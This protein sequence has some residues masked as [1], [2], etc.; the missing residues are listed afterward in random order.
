[1]AEDLVANP[2]IAPPRSLP[3]LRREVPPL[4]LQVSRALAVCFAVVELWMY[5]RWLPRWLDLRL[6]QAARTAE[7]LQ[8]GRPYTAAVWAAAFIGM[9]ALTGWCGTALL[10]LW[11]RSS[12]LF[13]VLIFLCFVSAGVIGS[14]DVF[15]ILR[16]QRSDQWAPWP[17]YV[18]YTANALCILWVFVFPDG[19]FVPPW[20]FLFALAWIAWNI[21]RATLT[22]ADLA[23]MGTYAVM[24]NFTL[25]AAAVGTMVYRYRWRATAVE[26]N[27]LKW[28]VVGCLFTLITYGGISVMFAAPALQQPG[29]GFLLRVGSTAL[30]SLALICVPAAML[31][32]IFRQ[33]LLDV[34]RLISR[35]L[36][37]AALTALLLATA[38]LLNS[39]LR[40]LMERLFGQVGD[41][42]LLVLA[43]PLAFAVLQ[44]RAPLVSA[45]DKALKER[46]V[47]SVMFIDIVESTATALR[48]G[49]DAW[50]TLLRRFR[51]TVRR[52]LKD[53]GGE[54]ID[55]AGDGFFATFAG[56]GGAVHCASDIVQ[57]VQRLGVHVRVGLHTGEVERYGVGVTGVAVHIGARIMSQAAPGQ[58]LVSSPMRDLLAGSRVR[59][60][61]IGEQ[62]LKGLPG[63]FRLYALGAPP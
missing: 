13:G 32:A 45:I 19:R 10:I 48:L 9:V 37:Y 2:A 27:Q 58:I 46:T 7:L 38:L 51:E 29:Q 41:L 1:M 22:A 49:D 54:E 33:G 23:A 4:V 3:L 28:L 57:D 43:L 34:N 30:L 21:T 36:V 62:K 59:L 42:M 55:T 11:R 5:F 50:A 16:L 8:D 14:T 24:L 18:M 20:G 15:E 60:V 44:L 17:V 26:R 40:Q 25:D 31:A 53:Y 47:I 6:G 39:V 61:D 56:P 35:T 63:V 12:D 52:H